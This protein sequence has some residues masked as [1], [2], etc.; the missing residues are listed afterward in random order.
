[1]KKIKLE[2]MRIDQRKLLLVRSAER[3]AQARARAAAAATSPP[4]PVKEPS[5]PKAT[6]SAPDVVSPSTPL[7]G[8]RSPLHPSL[9]AK[10]GLTPSKT[11]DA[12]S[13]RP[14]AVTPAPAPVPVVVTVPTSALV[15]TASP[16]PT[17]LPPDDQINRLE[18]VRFSL[19]VY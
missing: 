10:P 12:S 19:C 16:A 6:L 8:A 18:E 9:P 3:M 11:D 15:A 4:S 7:S 13:V 14:P 17:A 1:M 5:T 2:D